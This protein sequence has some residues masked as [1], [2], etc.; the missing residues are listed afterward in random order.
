MKWYDVFG[1]KIIWNGKKEKEKK[2]GSIVC[3][4]EKLSHLFIQILVEIYLLVTEIFPWN[5]SWN[6]RT[7][8]KSTKKGGEK[9]YSFSLLQ[10]RKS[11]LLHITK[12]ARPKARY[13]ALFFP[14]QS[15]EQ[16]LLKQLILTGS[17][18]LCKRSSGNMSRNERLLKNCALCDTF[19]CKESEKK[20][21]FIKFLRFRNFGM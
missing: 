14:N 15:L 2:I 16:Q 21:K 9:I 17:F 5:T 20:I 4:S 11:E 8:Q 19:K 12:S 7:R 1:L 13:H 3:I 18:L 6:V 10:S